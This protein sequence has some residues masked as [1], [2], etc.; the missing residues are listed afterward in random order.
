[1]PTILELFKNS[2]LDGQVK[3]DK[4]TKVE[5]EL[6]GVRTRSAAEINNPLIYGTD[7]FRIANRT[8]KMKD[9][10]VAGTAGTPAEDGAIQKGLKKLGNSKAAKKVKG[11]LDKFK[12]SKAGGALSKIVGKAPGDTNPSAILDEI[13]EI[14]QVQSQYPQK[15]S[16]IKGD[17]AGSG[18]LKNGLGGNPKTAAQQ[19][20][21]KAIQKAKDEIRGKLFGSPAGLGTNDPDTTA[22]ETYNPDGTYTQKRTED[23]GEEVYTSKIQ[24]KSL[25]EQVVRVGKGFKS[26]TGTNPDGT[27]TTVDGTEGVEPQER[28]TIS[29]TQ[30]NPNGGDLFGKNNKLIS[31]KGFTNKDD[32][33]N[34]SGIY[35]E[36]LTVDGK[37][38]DE[39][40]FIPLKFRNIVTNETVNFRGT[41]TGLSETVT[42][43]WDSNRFSGNPFNYYT[44]QS[45]ER[46]VNFNFTIYPMNSAELV[47]NWTKIEFLT[48]LLYPFGYQSGEIGSVRAPIIYFTM[49]DL[50]KDKVS[51]I[52]SLQY[53]VPDNSTWQLDGTLK[54][55]E[56][57][58]EFFDRAGATKKSV[59][60][61][62]KLPH[63]VEVAISLKFLE[64][65]SN[66][67]DRTKLYSFDSLTY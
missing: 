43:S 40:D 49:G 26:V 31:D 51:F 56:S 64:Q 25:E 62:Y 2:G 35:K 44:Y 61:G 67:E 9:S 47:N 38:I 1:M 57:S 37:S 24:Y 8:T 46:G 29:F 10:M 30:S 33:I 16:E 15:L 7:T 45:V 4:V 12:D 27:Q 6:T 60:N 53:T 42:P 55:Y 21:G 34:Q 22:I 39:Y 65:R 52:D 36:T 50:Y 17:L 11:K 63:M 54:D 18:L 20:A 23:A 5:Q 32:V 3:P 66:T 59:K 28:G 14:N 41:I 48:S 13:K 58:G 19:A